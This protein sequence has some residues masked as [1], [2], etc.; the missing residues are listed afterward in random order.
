VL[1]D[2]RW[3]YRPRFMARL[4]VLVLAAC[5][6]GLS[7]TV[8][9]EPL[10][11]LLPALLK[12]DPK[13]L[14]AKADLEAAADSLRGA[15]GGWYPSVDLT[16]DHGWEHTVKPY[17]DDTSIARSK[18]DLSVTQLISD[19]GATSSS[20]AVAESNYA[21]AEIAL[22]KARQ[23]LTL[24]AATA[25]LNL[26][27]A[28]ETLAYAS[29][30]EQNIKRQTGMEEARVQRGSGLRTDVLQAKSAL[31]GAQATR[32]RAEGSL[33]NAVN[34][35]RA[36]FNIPLGDLKTFKRPVLPLASLPRDIDEAVK[37]ALE[38]S[39]ILRASDYDAQIAR[40]TV[41][42]KRAAFFPKLELV[43]SAKHKENDAGTMGDKEETKVMV[44]LT[45]PLFS[46]GSDSA[47]YRAAGA[48]LRAT[49]GRLDD[50][51]RL[52]EEAIRNSWQSMITARANA[53]FLRNQANIS[54]EFLDLARKERRLGKR[55]ALDVLNGETNF[56]NAL[57]S[58]SS[59]EADYA[60][61]IYNVLHGMGKLTPDLFDGESPEQAG[62]QTVQ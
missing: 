15:K 58:A 2:S 57:S 47:A 3:G 54:G 13:I 14:A 50:A 9:A 22:E 48:Q 34:R 28:I 8:V 51:R 39:L 17:D 16:A 37:V 19:F 41:R 4:T 31:A 23:D 11:E 44:Q 53:D 5:M 60:L 12:S 40:Q 33:A 38:N 59:A 18:I 49:M 24:E 1:T 26:L 27:R 36:V 56:Y 42:T 62:R 32:V 20:I 52:V 61:A 21:K 6:G 30:S 55:S 45:Y 35:F 29:R 43:G 7:Q 25:Y 10:D 46:G